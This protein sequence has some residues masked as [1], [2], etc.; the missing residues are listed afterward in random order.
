MHLTNFL[1]IIFYAAIFC[2]TKEHHMSFSIIILNEDFFYSFLA[3]SFVF[4]LI[5][6][7]CAFISFNCRFDIVKR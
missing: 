5:F 7:Y 2:I 4:F 6:N 3:I 1:K